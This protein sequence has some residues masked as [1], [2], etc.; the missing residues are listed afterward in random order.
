MP[1]TEAMIE[2][3]LRNYKKLQEKIILL[4]YEIT[5]PIKLSSSELL[6]ALAFGTSKNGVSIKSTG[7]SYDRI[8]YLAT[9]YHEMAEKMN[10]EAN[11][12]AVQE[13][14]KLM[15]EVMRMEKYISLLPELHQLILRA[16]YIDQKSWNDLQ[17]E[18]GLSRRTLIRKKLLSI[19]ALTEMYCY[20]TNIS[21][22]Q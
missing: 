10:E 3:K 13:W 12:A 22:K 8:A 18:T 2:E 19:S 16:L 6:D 14:R 11:S 17:Q 1:F 4:E 5:H 21:M 7:D 20:I 9:H 15:E